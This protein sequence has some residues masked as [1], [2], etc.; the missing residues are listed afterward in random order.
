MAFQAPAAPMGDGYPVQVTMTDARE[1]NRLWGIPFLGI[2]VSSCPA[3]V[4]WAYR[5]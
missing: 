4:G 3:S 1:I 2:F 5:A